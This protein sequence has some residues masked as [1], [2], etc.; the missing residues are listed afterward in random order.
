MKVETDSAWCVFFRLI[1]CQL[2]RVDLE[3]RPLDELVFV[4]GEILCK[5]LI[6]RRVSGGTAAASLATPSSTTS[7]SQH[8]A[9]SLPE[10]SSC[11]SGGC[12]HLKQRC[13]QL[14]LNGFA[15]GVYAPL[16]A[17]TAFKVPWYVLSV[18]TG[19]LIWKCRSIKHHWY[20]Q[21]NS[22]L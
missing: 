7:S 6:G 21:R 15:R 16:L 4:F 20:Y 11:S 22:C 8:L 18:F 14:T 17:K 10:L 2:A 9:G 5:L 3:E 12:S 13:T 19:L 1:W